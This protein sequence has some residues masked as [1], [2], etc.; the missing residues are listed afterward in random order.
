MQKSLTKDSA[1]QALI[2]IYLLSLLLM[3][4]AGSSV[5][6][7]G[8]ET[9]YR[10]FTQA[11]QD[12][13]WTDAIEHAQHLDQLRP[14]D[15][16]TQYNLA[17]VLALQ[18][19]PD[20]ALSWLEKAAQNGFTDVEALKSDTDFDSLHSLPGWSGVIGT[21]NDNRIRRRARISQ[22][23]ATLPS[24]ISLPD[25]WD[26]ATPAPLIIALHGYGGRAEN[27]PG[28]WRRAAAEK[29]AIVV[30]PWGHS[31]VYNGSSWTDLFEAETIVDLTIAWVAERYPIDRQ[32]IVLSGFSQGG[33]MSY[34]IAVRRPEL[35]TGVIPMGAGYAPNFDRPPQAGE[36]SPRYYFM[37]G[38][39]DKSAAQTKRAAADFEAAGYE[40]DLRV[41]PQSGHSFP[42]VG[43]NREL[44]KALLFVLP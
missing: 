24:P 35:F 21:I 43:K 41:Y 10:Q 29:G 23:F 42:A 34:A 1:S 15:P 6:A 39:D 19:D 22:V 31:P 32:R 37:I 44:T 25:N 40:V 27:F 7:P 2:R 20:A 13:Q 18:G 30:A 38:V 16:P 12:Q 9:V 8:Y 4:T 33:Y 28:L 14:D 3:L 11:Y 36:H 17:C 26:G 5:A